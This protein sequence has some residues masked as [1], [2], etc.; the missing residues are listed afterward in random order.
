MT[1]S[2][3]LKCFKDANRTNDMLCILPKSDIGKCVMQA[4]E[5]QI[6]KKPIII[7]EQTHDCVTEFEYE[8][9]ICGNI[10]IELAPCNEWCQ[11]CGNKFDWSNGGASN[12]KI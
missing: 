3:A 10:Y 4:L 2:E 5:K 11:N 12:D 8:C 9:P 6:P 1:E 7:F